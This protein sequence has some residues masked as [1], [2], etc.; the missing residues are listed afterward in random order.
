M[1]KV[2]KQLKSIPLSGTDIYNACE[3]KI[4]VLKYGQLLQF[5]TIDEAFNPYDAIALLYEIEK[6]YGHWVLLLRHRERG[7]I[8]FF[9]SYGMFIDDQLKHVSPA[10]KAQSGQDFIYL[11]ELLAKS[12]Y[13]VIYN[14]HKIQSKKENVSS[15]GRHL[16]LRYLMKETPLKEYIKIVKSGGSQNPDDVATYL[17]AFI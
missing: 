4:K 5:Q 8:E 13:K 3:K 17:T 2:I 1:N 9:D 10:F 15:C 7:I 11:S 16:C 12:D 6:N 14:K